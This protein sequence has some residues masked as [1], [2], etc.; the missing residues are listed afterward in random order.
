MKKLLIA[1][2][3]LAMLWPVASFAGG[4]PSTTDTVLG[5][6]ETYTGEWF[7]TLNFNTITVSVY[8]DV[9]SASGGL[10]IEW[11]P[12]KLYSADCDN[13]TIDAAN[14]EPF[15]FS[16][17]FRYCRLIY[18]NGSSGQ[19]LF[20]LSA[21]VKEGGFKASSHAIGLAIDN[22]TDATLSKSVVTGLTDDGSFINVKTTNPGNLRVTSM[23]FA[24]DVALGNI[25]GVDKV[26]KFGRNEAIG[27]AQEEIW[28]GSTQYV[29]IP[30]N[31]D[32]L[33]YI[34][35]SNVNDD[36]DYE[37]MGLDV[38]G[39]PQIDTVTVN[40]QN[41]V[42]SS[43]Q[44]WRV[45]RVMNLELQ[46]TAFLDGN[47]GTIY[48]STASSGSS[49]VPVAASI[50]AIVDIGKN[51]TTMAMWT[52]PAGKKAL[53]IGFDS[54]TSGQKS[55]LIELFVRPFGGVFQIK[56]P[57]KIFANPARLPYIFPLV[58]AAKS[59]IAIVGSTAA[60]GGDASAGFEIFYVDE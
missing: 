38:D 29:Y 49:G 45:Y 36:Q 58:A 2:V 53:I 13:Y 8:S 52:V 55:T 50:K 33:L 20:H 47:E 32:S 9:V 41:F 40:G 46:D 19:S 39:V 23:P 54:S 26:T 1:I 51:Q 48:I 12:N 59:D 16:P 37:I 60:T 17:A 3:V 18:T 15:T 31:E 34:S 27:S 42:E 6:D 56:K 35:S 30:D 4:I 25:L 14:G 7:D 28:S 10:A 5:S 44:W 21:T 24:W 22:D 57:M 43:F 11:S